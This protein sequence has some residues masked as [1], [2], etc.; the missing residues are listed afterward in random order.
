M[1]TQVLNSTMDSSQ[2]NI[3]LDPLD[4]DDPFFLLYLSESGLSMLDFLVQDD[5]KGAATVDDPPATKKRKTSQHESDTAASQSSSSSS[6]VSTSSST[7]YPPKTN[8][9]TSVKSITVP[10]HAHL[11]AQ[12]C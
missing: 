2:L 5:D 10:S 3:Q 11:S 9:E 4:D 1:A 6:S 8:Q 7:V 12:S